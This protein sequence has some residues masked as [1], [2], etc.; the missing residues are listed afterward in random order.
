MFRRSGKVFAVFVLLGL[1]AGG[2]GWLYQQREPSA[3]SQESDSHD[4]DHAHDALGADEAD[5]NAS[6]VRLTPQ[7]RKNLGLVSHPLRPTPFQRTI[8]IPGVIV[9]RPGVSDRGVVAPVTGVVTKIHHYPG[10][11]VEPNAPLFAIRL[12]SESLHA[13]QLEMFK[14]TREIEIATQ[15]RARLAE[16]SRS[17]AISQARLIEIE[18]KIRLLDATVQAY[19]QDLQARGLPAER[20][21]AA[22]QGEFVTEIT[23]HAPT[24]HTAAPRQDS[25]I[26][27]PAEES[28]GPAFTFEMHE[29]E[30]ELGEQVTAG[31]VLCKL[32]D[33]RSLF[34]EGRGFKEDMPLVQRAAKNGVEVEV[35]YEGSVGSEWP[36]LPSKLPIHHV[37]NT[38]DRESRTFG[39]YLPLKNQWSDYT[40]EG[41]TRLLWRFRPGDR[42]RIHV[43]V[44]TFENVFVLPR[45]GLVREGPQTYVFRQNGDL[46]DRRPVHVLYED[47]RSVV[48]ANDR[49]VRPGTPI[50]HNGAASLNRVLKAQAAS[51]QPAGVHVHADGTVHGAH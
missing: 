38:V 15:E 17:G 41:K 5:A 37:A 34:I 47:R 23:V 35:E 9:D 21:A 26:D 22:A 51:G 42:A 29:L 43:A 13:S 36:E 33:H 1:L 27:A 7:A 2:G 12:V 32:A 50:A 45:E 31:E 8:E 30:V 46:F 39:F 4:H 24:E 10:D 3:A 25:A 49:S 48:I 18:N 14:A 11:T 16:A 19:E 40:Q 20:I 28:G 6:V 44:E